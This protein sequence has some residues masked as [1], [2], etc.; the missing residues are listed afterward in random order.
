MLSRKSMRRADVVASCLFMALGGGVI[1]SAWQMPWAT[2]RTGGS[3]QWYL[4]PGLFPAI[5][6][7]LLVLFS[8]RVLLQAVREGGHQGLM[9]AIRTWI[10]GLGANRPVHRAFLIALLMMIYVF[11]GV[12]RINFHVASGLFLF[13]SIALFWW[14]MSGRPLA[15]N[16]IITALVAVLTPLVIGSIFTRLLDVPMP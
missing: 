11:L 13:A 14:P 10:S 3:P 15:V 9:P 16:V 12:G 5:I 8:A 6:G 7:V 2:Q 4:S 1:Y